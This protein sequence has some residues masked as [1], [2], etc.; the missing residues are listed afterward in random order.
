M[1]QIIKIFILTK[2]IILFIWTGTLISL[3][4]LEIDNFKRAQLYYRTMQM[5]ILK[6][7][8]CE[9]AN[10]MKPQVK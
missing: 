8:L 2:T 5:L 6:T 4:S 10:E 1:D 9:G 7:L 3:A